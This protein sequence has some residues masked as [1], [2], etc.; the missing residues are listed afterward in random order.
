MQEP[1]PYLNYL[2]NPSFQ[3][4]NILFVSSFEKTADR[5]VHTK[6]YFPT[7]EIKDFNFMIDGQ[8]FFDQPVKKNLRIYDNIWKIATGPGDDYSTSC[9]LDYHYFN[10]YYEMIA[11]GLSKQQAL[12]A[13]TKAIQ[14]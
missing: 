6:Y 7:V 1:N 11:I 5:T 14:Y 9:L 12:D 13:D 8:N 10:K 4:V 2:I 3:E